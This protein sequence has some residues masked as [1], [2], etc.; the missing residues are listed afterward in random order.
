MQ[1]TEISYRELVN[2]GNYQNIAVEMK[3]SIGITEDLEICTIRLKNKVQKAL[4][5]IQEGE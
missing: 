5:Q 3:A 4:N 2:T 1:I